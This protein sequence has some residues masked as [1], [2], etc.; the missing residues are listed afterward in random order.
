MAINEACQVW[1]EQRIQEE[2]ESG[3]DNLSAL[4]RELAAEV[5]RVFQTRIS[6]D[7]L[8]KRADRFIRTNV[9]QEYSPTPTLPEPGDSGDMVTAENV[10][11]RINRL[12]A[13]GRS[14]RDAAEVLSEQTGQKAESIRKM[15]SRKEYEDQH[16]FHGNA[17]GMHYA[18]RAV[19]LLNMIPDSD[20]ELNE[21]LNHVAA[22]ISKRRG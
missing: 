3:A 9:Q 17:M 15:F 1:I 6:P 12:V 2:L 22:F 13:K 5:E 4:G 16:K 11:E 21:A 18:M 8:R 19:D 10:Q 14:I 20:P 7:T